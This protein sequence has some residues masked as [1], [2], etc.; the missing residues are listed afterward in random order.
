MA[1]DQEIKQAVEASNRVIEEIRAEV[2]SGDVVAR[3][4]LARMEAGLA[5]VLSVKQEMEAF[6]AAMENR[7]TAQEAKANRPGVIAAGDDGEYKAAFFDFLR[8]GQH[9]GAEAKLLSLHE[10]ATDVRYSTSASGGYALPKVIAAEI[11]QIAV[12]ISPIR[13]ISRVVATGTTDYHELVDLTGFATEWVG[14]TDTRNQTNTSDLYDVVP[15]FGEL[16]AKPEATRQAIS[17]LF[18]DVESWLVTT[19]GT[20]FAKAEG[21]AFVSGNGTNKPT[22]FLTGTPVS[23]ADASRA[24]GTLQYV[25]SGQASALA[26]NPFDTFNTL[27]FTLK[28]G[29]RANARWVLNSLT[30]AQLVNVKDTTGRYL[31]QASPALGV[32]DTMLGRPVVIAEDMPSIAANALPVAVGDFSQGYLIADIPGMWALR[33]ELTKTGYVRFP[34]AKRVG[35]KLKDT[36][37]IKLLKVAAS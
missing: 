29:Y 9:A 5:D 16:S 17:D 35:G 33:D 2:K 3:E 30:L 36:N 32:P 27:F 15:T 8:K 34:M 23:T 6:K 25:A 13:S 31:L 4:K 11:A 10:K 20:M 28:Q 24:F 21:A 7:L 1:L 18:F 26:S 12:D 19:A 14:E 22:G 37:A